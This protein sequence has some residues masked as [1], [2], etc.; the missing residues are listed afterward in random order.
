[1]SSKV[2]IIGLDGATFSVLDPLI[3]QGVMPFLS[4]FM[5]Q[6]ARSDLRSVVPPLTPPAWTSLMTGRSPGHHGVFD[7]FRME[8]PETRHIRFMTSRDVNGETIWS[9]AA[10]AGKRVTVLNFPLT[11][12]PPKIAG[13]IV[14]GWVPWRQ[15]RIAC[16]PEGL[17]DRLKQLPGFDAREL[18]M[19]MKLEEKA[20]EGCEDT[21]LAPWIE[22]HTRREQ[23][24]FEVLQE[25]RQSD[26]CELTAI[27][28]DGVDR[29][30]HLCWRFI[31]APDESAFTSDWER[32]MRALCLTY[33]RNLDEILAQACAQAGPETTI[34]MTSDHGFGPTEDVFHV[35]NWLAQRG[36]LAWS[37]DARA[38]HNGN[39]DS[40]LLG[41]GQVAR[42]TFLLDWNR[43]KAFATTPT[44]NGIYIVAGGN[45]TAGVASRDYT[46]FRETLKQEL[47]ELRHPDTGKPVVTRVWT[48]EE[49]FAG[50]YM[51][52]APDLTLALHDGGLFSILPS[53][54]VFSRRPH[55]SGAHR[56]EGIFIAR[57]PGV[58]E[59]AVLPELSILDIAPL[60]LYCL[61]LEI[62]GEL[63]GRVPQAIFHPSVLA[64]RAVRVS[65]EVESPQPSAAVAAA[66]RLDPE[67]EALI[68]ERLRHLGYIE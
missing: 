15:L 47:L 25:L 35:N 20:T 45:G 6:G 21:E 56:P 44:S 62:P 48:R 57:G 38:S 14:P 32:R 39:G 46:A 55:L 60:V 1:M 66:E 27:I 30:Q 34:V 13:N 58:R 9:R 41:V 36:Y 50:P 22:L 49:A 53:E 8:S 28:F 59:G 26:P 23:R 18:A 43:T 52:H 54:K 19:D 42:H 10:R 7:F 31:A 17:F 40:A 5:A 67:D 33:F 24:W 2:L 11:F 12:P 65:R 16:W 3:A 37:Q 63:E 61:G 4:K 68:L 51:A 64:Q 29:L